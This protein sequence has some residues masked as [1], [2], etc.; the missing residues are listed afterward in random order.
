MILGQHFVGNEYDKGSFYSGNRTRNEKKLE[1]YIEQALEG[2]KTN[3]FLYIA[4]P[5]LI[6][7]KGNKDIYV[8]KMTYFAKELKKLDCP[9]EFNMLGFKE[10]RNYP[11]KLFWQIVSEVGNDVIIGLDAHNPKAY[12]EKD[13]YEKA[14]E[15]L[16][17]LD[18]TPLYELDMEEYKRNR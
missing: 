12:L 10:G 13:Y 7:F 6:N 8:E 17:E 14:L 16:K 4:H 11:N 1:Q 18:I 2:I 5:D 15:F 3:Q 9:V